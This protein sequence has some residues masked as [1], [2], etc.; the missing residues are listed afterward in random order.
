MRR[1][2]LVIP[3]IFIFGCS[4]SAKMESAEDAA[5]NDAVASCIYRNGNPK[6]GTEEYRRVE[7]MC[8]SR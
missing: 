8:E 3:Y 7:R 1:I 6:Y 5:Y 4:D 2:L